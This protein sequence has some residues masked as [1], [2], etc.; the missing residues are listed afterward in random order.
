MFNIAKVNV[1]NINTLKVFLYEGLVANNIICNLLSC[2]LHVTGSPMQS[3]V[4]MRVSEAWASKV[5]SMFAQVNGMRYKL[6]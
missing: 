2:N 1:K 3:S 5:S 4:R 6:V